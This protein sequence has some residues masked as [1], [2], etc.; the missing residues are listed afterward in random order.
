MMSDYSHIV[1]F[2]IGVHQANANSSQAHQAK[3]SF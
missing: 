3:A 1:Y 2:F